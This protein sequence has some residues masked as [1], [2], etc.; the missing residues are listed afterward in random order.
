VHDY[1]NLFLH[2]SFKQCDQNYDPF[3]SI[4][5]SIISALLCAH[6][7]PLAGK[8]DPDYSGIN[9]SDRD[10]MRRSSESMLTNIGTRFYHLGASLPGNVN[11]SSSS[12]IPIVNTNHL[13]SQRAKKERKKSN[14]WPGCG[15]RLLRRGNFA[16]QAHVQTLHAKTHK[17]SHHNNYNRGNLIEVR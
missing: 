8:S 5:S 2:Y 16:S 9:G 7:S 17:V 6:A 1:G 4:L 10:A 3:S 14:R 13:I 12:K 15:R 11:N